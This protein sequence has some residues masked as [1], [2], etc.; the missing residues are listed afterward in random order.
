MRQ[1]G[2]A[3]FAG[4]LDQA[5]QY[6]GLRPAPSAAF[7]LQLTSLQDSKLVAAIGGDG[8]AVEYELRRVIRYQII[9]GDWR[10]VVF[11]ESANRRLSFEPSQ[12]LAK[13]LEETR[14]RQ[15][16]SRELIELII[17]RAEAELRQRSQLEP[18]APA[19]GQ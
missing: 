10:S 2:M 16:L 11:S 17:L 14:L 6:R 9:A 3:E 5:L 19:S 8:K 15:A 4:L 7:S 18:P 1:P 12:V 13:E